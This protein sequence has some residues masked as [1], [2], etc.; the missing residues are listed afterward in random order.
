MFWK[1]KTPS[2]DYEL[3]EQ[4]KEYQQAMDTLKA[5]IPVCDEILTSRGLTDHTIEVIGRIWS[6]DTWG[7]VL[8]LRNSFGRLICTSDSASDFKEYV[9]SFVDDY[10]DSIY[11]H[12]KTNKFGVRKKSIGWK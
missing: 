4:T 1:K 2:S 6:V 9:T 3:V 7:V 8:T 5:E 12:Q 11:T 10:Y